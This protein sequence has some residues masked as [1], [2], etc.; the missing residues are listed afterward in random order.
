MGRSIL[1]AQREMDSVLYYQEMKKFVGAKHHEAIDL[2]ID[3]ERMHFAFLSKL[4]R[5]VSDI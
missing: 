5:E 4:R 2:I 3:A 1:P